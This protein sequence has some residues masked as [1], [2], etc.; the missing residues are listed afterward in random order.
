MAALRTAN[1]DLID[2]FRRLA[3]RVFQRLLNT[4][5]MISGLLAPENAH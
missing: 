2:F 5:A 3:A 4:K 1:D